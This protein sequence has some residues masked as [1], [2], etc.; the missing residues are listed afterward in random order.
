M[1]VFGTKTRWG[2]PSR[3]PSLSGL[4]RQSIFSKKAKNFSSPVKIFKKK[5]F[6]R[7]VFKLKDLQKSK[8]NSRRQRANTKNFWNALAF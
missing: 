1:R 4:T 8:K 6:I 2:T 7:K 3:S 5:A